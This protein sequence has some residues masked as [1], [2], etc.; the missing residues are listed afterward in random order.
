MHA[1][2]SN[3]IEAIGYDAES[4]TLEVRFVSGG[5]YRYFEVSPETAS[6][7][8]AADSKGRFFHDHILDR[9]AFERLSTQ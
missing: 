7:F 3:A 9:Y 4:R 5:D 6:A 2:D 8:A 1:V